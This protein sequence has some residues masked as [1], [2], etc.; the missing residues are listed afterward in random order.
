MRAHGFAQRNGS[1]EL[2]LF[3]INDINAIAVVPGLPTPELP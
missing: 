3:Q 1:R 2:S